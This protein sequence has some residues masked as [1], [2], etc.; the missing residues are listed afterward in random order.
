[1]FARG[2]GGGGGEL[3]GLEGWEFVTYQ[4]RLNRLLSTMARLTSP[5][6]TGND[7]Q[8]VRNLFSRKNAIKVKKSQFFW[9]EQGLNYF[10]FLLFFPANPRG[11]AA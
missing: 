6:F 5:K 4:S 9:P 3:G 2:E 8:D 11:G 7:L 1:M 10:F